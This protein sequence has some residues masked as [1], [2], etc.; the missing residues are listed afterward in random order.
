MK[1]F[2]NVALAVVVVAGPAKRD[3]ETNKC[4]MLASSCGVSYENCWDECALGSEMP[5]ISEPACTGS[6]SSESSPLITPTPAQLGLFWEEAASTTCPELNRCDDLFVQCGLGKLRYGG[7]Y[8][9]CGMPPWPKPTCT[10]PATNG[11]VTTTTSTTSPT[12]AKPE[13][14]RGPCTRKFCAPPGW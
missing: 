14:T 7:C 5:S 11:T 3:C 8:T 1:A 13:N 12:S 4:V 6:Q 2:L 10:L 9:A